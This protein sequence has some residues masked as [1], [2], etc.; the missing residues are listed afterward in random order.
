M[1][2]SGISP[3][4]IGSE[5]GGAVR[6]PSTYCGIFGIKPSVGRLCPLGMAQVKFDEICMPSHLI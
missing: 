6:L 5:S 4:G 3:L 1:I 2:L